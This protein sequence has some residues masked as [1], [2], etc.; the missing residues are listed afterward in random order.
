VESELRGGT[1]PAEEEANALALFVASGD[2]VSCDVE[3]VVVRAAR[4]STASVVGL[5]FIIILC[6]IVIIEIG[7]LVGIWH[8]VTINRSLSIRHRCHGHS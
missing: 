6:I 2:R 8:G 3:L 4:R 7:I 5:D 1:C